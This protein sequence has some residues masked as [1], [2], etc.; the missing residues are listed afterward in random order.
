MEPKLDSLSESNHVSFKIISKYAL[1]IYRSSKLKVPDWVEIVKNSRR[2]ELSPYDEDWFFACAA[3]VARHLYIMRAPV[4]SVSVLSARSTEVR[5]A[6]FCFK[7]GAQ[8]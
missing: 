3:S 4:A 1:F 7:F 8:A 6:L 5:S 2:S